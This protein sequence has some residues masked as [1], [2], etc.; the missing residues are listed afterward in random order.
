MI[1]RDFGLLVG[2]N[3]FWESYGIIIIYGITDTAN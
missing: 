1:S 3:Y 2:D